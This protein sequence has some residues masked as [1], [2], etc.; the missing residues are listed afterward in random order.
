MRIMLDANVIISAILFPK[1]IVAK[2]FMHMIDNY[3]LV[4]SKYTIDEVEDVFNEK[5]PHKTN[6]IKILMI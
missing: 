2:A 5:F 4:L 3:S 6:E 1:S